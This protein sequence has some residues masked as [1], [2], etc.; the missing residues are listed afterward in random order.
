MTDGVAR[1][2][3]RV[4]RIVGQGKCPQKSARFHSVLN[5]IFR[6]KFTDI[7]VLQLHPDLKKSRQS[8]KQFG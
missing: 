6:E 4:V 1:L 7:D 3:F 5:G 2:F 8:D